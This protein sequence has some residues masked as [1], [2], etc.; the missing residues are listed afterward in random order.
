[1]HRDR[2]WVVEPGAGCG[3]SEC[4][5]GTECQFG[6]PRKFWRRTVGTVEKQRETT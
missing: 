1:M 3:G 5:K 4:S 2:K 6:T